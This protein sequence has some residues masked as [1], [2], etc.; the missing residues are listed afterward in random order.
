MVLGHSLGALVALTLATDQPG[1]FGAVLLEDPPA[2][3]GSFSVD[4]VATDLEATTARTKA[5]PTAEVQRLT[6]DN[7]SWSARDVAGFLENRQRLDLLPVT[8][9]LRRSSWDLPALVAGAG[10]VACRAAR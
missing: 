2:L 10:A 9:V 5:D 4:D 1:R 8:A 3:G 7:Q 6:E